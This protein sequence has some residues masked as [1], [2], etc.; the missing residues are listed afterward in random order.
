VNNKT[1]VTVVTP[2][3]NEGMSIA[4]TLREFFIKFQGSLLNI[5]FVVSEDGSTDN[6][7]D[8]IKKV[9]KEFNITL[10]SDESRKGY[11]KA[12]VDGLRLVDEGLVSFIDSDG[13]CDPE[14]LNH[15]L[16]NYDGE[17]IVVGY[18]NPRIDSPIRKLMSSLFKAVY[19]TIFKIR[20]KDPSCP[21]FLTSKK[22]VD[23]I[24]NT[25]EIGLLKQGFWWEFYARAYSLGINFIEVPI[26]HRSRAFGQTV[27]YRFTKVPRIA[28]EHIL[29]L[30]ELKKICKKL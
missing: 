20:L 4:S 15:L 13:Q 23:L 16:D 14:D 10:I 6:S 7:V 26:N 18:R 21:Y 28:Y 27:V 29:A 19:F 3:H 22:N 17:S 9:K 24:L 30:F 2:V 25:P 8:E 12:V 5:K 11:S 1:S